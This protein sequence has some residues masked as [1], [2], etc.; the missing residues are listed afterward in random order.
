MNSTANVD[1]IQI[2]IFIASAFD[3]EC[4]VILVKFLL[5]PM[6]C[7]IQASCLPFAYVTIS[8][9][10]T[11]VTNEGRLISDRFE[12]SFLP[13]SA[14][15]SQASNNRDSVTGLWYAHQG[16]IYPKSRCI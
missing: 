4:P 9:L 8:K 6:L 12:I 16:L 15:L 11:V 2:L 1:I 14:Q 7:E 3:T 13:R 5:L 10:V